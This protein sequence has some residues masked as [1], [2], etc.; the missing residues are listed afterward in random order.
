MATTINPA[1][2]MQQILA[3]ENVTPDS[4]EQYFVKKAIDDAGSGGGGSDLPPA[5]DAGNVM[6]SDGEKWG[7]AAPANNDF[8]VTAEISV[9]GGG[10]FVLSNPLPNF[11]DTLAAIKAG[12]NVRFECASDALGMTIVGQGNLGSDGGAITFIST[13]YNPAIG[14]NRL[15]VIDYFAGDSMRIEIIPDVQDIPAPNAVYNGWVLGVN[16]GAYSL[17]NSPLI[18]TFGVDAGTSAISAD[19]SV[20]DI[21]AAAQTRPVLGVLP[22]GGSSE[23]LVFTQGGAGT[24]CFSLIE[25]DGATNKPK[26]ITCLFGNYD[27]ALQ[28]DSW[29]TEDCPL[30][31]PI[32]QSVA[33]YILAVSNDGKS[34]GWVSPT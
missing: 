31:P 22:M 34:I 19:M 10:D 3:G 2:K 11:A 29:D 27:S 24:V 21:I 9:D 17:V 8:T 12:K 28:T 5:G 18:V 33:G 25:M 32:S 4:A 13:L 15:A 16:G 30:L 1:T 20:N 26:G 23:T 6:T 7:S 14:G